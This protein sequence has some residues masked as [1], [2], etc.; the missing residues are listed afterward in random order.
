MKGSG[1][2]GKGRVKA[3]EGEGNKGDVEGWWGWQ[4]D[5]DEVESQYKMEQSL[6]AEAWPDV[7]LQKKQMKITNQINYVKS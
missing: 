4:W 7:T 6:V 2:G 1:K 3:R 5:G